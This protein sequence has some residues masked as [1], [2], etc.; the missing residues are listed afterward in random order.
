MLA[1]GHHCEEENFLME[2]CMS[3]L[4]WPGDKVEGDMADP[5]LDRYDRAGQCGSGGTEVG[6]MDEWRQGLGGTWGGDTRTDE[7]CHPVPQSFGG[8]PHKQ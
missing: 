4:P 2:E 7:V 3:A 1:P 6:G 5:R 8:M